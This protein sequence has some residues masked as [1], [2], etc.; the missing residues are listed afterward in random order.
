[1]SAVGAALRVAEVSV[2]LQPGAHADAPRS[3][4]K[5][6]QKKGSC[7]P[8][9]DMKAWISATRGS[10]AGSQQVISWWIRKGGSVGELF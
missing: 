5:N 8:A 2:A 9:G 7:D 4:S 1:M 3:V 6:K 10:R